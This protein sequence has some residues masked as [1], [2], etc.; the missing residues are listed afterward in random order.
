M[1]KEPKL[2]VVKDTELTKK[3][4]DAMPTQ[5]TKAPELKYKQSQMSNKLS[6]VKVYNQIWAGEISE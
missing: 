4:D 3:Y 6:T 2:K 1:K 5:N